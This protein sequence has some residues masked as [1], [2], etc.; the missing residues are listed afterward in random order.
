MRIPFPAVALASF[1]LG[2]G[3]ATQPKEDWPQ[4]GFTPMWSFA[5]QPE[6]A[7]LPKGLNIGNTH[8]CVEVDRAGRV[9]LN[10]D[11]EIAVMVFAPDGRY[12]R[13]FGG[14]LGGGLHGM[15]LVEENGEEFLYVAHTGLHQVRKMALTGKTLWTLGW[16]QESG[17]YTSETEYKPTAIAVAPDGRFWVADGYGKGMIHEYTADR[18]W[19]RSW[20]GHGKEAGKFRTPHG[21][22]W[23][24]IA[25]RLIVA[26]RENNRLQVFSQEGVHLQTIE[27]DLRRP[28]HVDAGQTGLAIA[29]LGGRVSVIT[30]QGR[31]LARLGNQP[32][33]QKRAK[34][35]IPPEQWADGEFLAPHC[36]AWNAQG[37]LFVA[38]WNFRGRLT[39]LVRL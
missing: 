12:L 25:A 13:G 8:G 24:P 23:D 29:E 14:E 20:G 16:P 32:D 22:T 4:W 34:N 37:D 3:L 21:I 39:K 6:W 27:A 9:Y 5:W 2:C 31:I 11:T 30:R 10:T 26:D 28:C 35:G 17:H 18:Q 1:L 15:D 7:S 33:P 38:D 36:A 19:V